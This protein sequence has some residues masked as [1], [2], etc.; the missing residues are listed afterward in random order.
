MVGESAW[1]KSEQGDEILNPDVE[2]V[3]VVCGEND[4]HEWGDRFV[5][6]YVGVAKGDFFIMSDDLDGDGKFQESISSTSDSAFHLT[7]ISLPWHSLDILPSHKA[8]M[9]GVA[10]LPP[11]A[12]TSKFFGVERSV[13]AP[14]PSCQPCPGFQPIKHRLRQSGPSRGANGQPAYLRIVD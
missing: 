10:K 3:K 8:V 9:V 2:Y 5:R 13:G 4:Y 14:I 6:G 7:T 12:T 1:I 11:L